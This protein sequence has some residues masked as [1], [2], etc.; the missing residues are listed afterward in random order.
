MIIIKITPRIS[1]LLDNPLPQREQNEVD[2]IISDFEIGRTTMIDLANHILTH[3]KDTNIALIYI[4]DLDN[5]LVQEAFYHVRDKVD[6]YQ[7]LRLDHFIDTLMYSASHVLISRLNR[8]G[9][10]YIDYLSS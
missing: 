10:I 3:F 1:E 4:Y 7:S 5:P 8:I 9:H 6:G 2:K